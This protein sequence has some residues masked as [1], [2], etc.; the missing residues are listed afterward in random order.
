[1]EENPLVKKAHH[2]STHTRLSRTEGPNPAAVLFCILLWLCSM[3][4]WGWGHVDYSNMLRLSSSCAC[5]CAAAAMWPMLMLILLLLKRRCSFQ[6]GAI[7]RKHGTT[8]R[9][10]RTA[11]HIAYSYSQSGV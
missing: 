9:S 3:D 10:N 1:V 2:R 11:M 8:H 5:A 7:K 4:A 6:A